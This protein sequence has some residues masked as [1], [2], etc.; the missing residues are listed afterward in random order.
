MKEHQ[1]QQ[2]RTDVRTDRKSKQ[3]RNPTVASYL[4]LGDSTEPKLLIKYAPPSEDQPAPRRS[5]RKRRAQDRGDKPTTRTRANSDGKKAS[6]QRRVSDS[7]RII[8]PLH[9]SFTCKLDGATE[10]ALPTP[11][12]TTFPDPT[13]PT[14]KQSLTDDED[15]VSCNLIVKAIQDPA[16]EMSQTYAAISIDDDEDLGQLCFDFEPNSHINDISAH[17]TDGI[18]LPQYAEVQVDGDDFGDDDLMDEDLLDLPTDT[19]DDFNNF[20]FQS[21]AP[22]QADVLDEVHQE[23][24]S[25]GMS[26]AK[27]VGLDEEVHISGPML[28]KFVS[29]VTLT[30]RL[31]TAIDEEAQKPI[32]RSAFP[33]A[34]RDRSPVI[35]LS[36][37]TVLKT[38]FRVGEAINQSCQ[39]V[40]TGNAILIELYA[41]VLVSERDSTQQR[42]TFVTFST[43]DRHM[44]KLCTLLRYGNPFSYLN[45]TAHA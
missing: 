22:I 21:S 1:S 45:T 7:R 11:A 40:K 8:E 30:T 39:A 25:S 24:R 10:V 4:G 34:V 38:C 5:V 18:D 31:L 17:P 44:S 3:H 33:A 42:F 9:H 28:G 12:S 26:A 20:K 43:P 16:V 15:Q 23:R 32:V 14:N 27:A 2:L 13:S 37:N 36:S 19:V 6:K 41:R 35:G 29:P